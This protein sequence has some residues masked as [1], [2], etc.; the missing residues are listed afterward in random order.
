[1]S[2][3]SSKSELRARALDLYNQNY[4]LVAIGKELGINVSTLRRWLREAGVAPKTN[5][6]AANP[7]PDDPDPL[8]TALDDNLEGKTEE[9]IKLAKHDA[10]LKE[11]ESMMEVAEAQSSPAEKY[12]CY[13]AAAGIK[14]LRDSIKNLRGPKTVKELSEL[15]QLIR[16]NMGL[17]AKTAGG[18]GKLQIDISILN[19]AKADRGKGAVKINPK[20]IIEVTPLEDDT[21]G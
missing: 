6:H 14:L 5:S 21:D 11:D 18:G 15:D 17:N 1:V 2:K 13:I 3:K 8:Q 12:Q 9:A 10:R 4:K 19:N 20:K 16:R 7:L